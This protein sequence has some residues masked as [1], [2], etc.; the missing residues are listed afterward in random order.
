MKRSLLF[1]ALFLFGGSLFAQDFENLIDNPSFEEK[2]GDLRRSGQIRKAKGWV[3]G[4][5]E[6]ADLYTEEEEGSIG[7]PD[8]EKGRAL[9]H[10]G[11][12]YAGVRFFSFGDDEP[13][14]Y[15][16][17]KLSS[18]LKD[19]VTYCVKFYVSLSDRSIYGVNNI[20]AY[21]SKKDITTPEETSLIYEANVLDK[22][23][24]IFEDRQ[25]WEPVCAAYEAEGGEKYLTIGNFYSSSETETR[26]LEPMPDFSDKPPF[27]EAYY[28]IDDVSVRPVESYADCQCEEEEESKEPKVVYSKPEVDESDFSPEQKMN[29]RALYFGFF[30]A[31]LEDKA[32]EELGKVYTLLQENPDMEIEVIGHSDNKEQKK[33]EQ[34]THLKDKSGERAKA[35]VEYLVDKGISKD[36]LHLKAMQNSQPAS[37]GTDAFSRAKNRR[38]VFKVKE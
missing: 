17:S 24:K 29:N 15:I 16:S 34:Y 14:T 6:G 8:N 26:K 12:R 31:S 33:T 18:K 11:Q 36:R 19:G 32:K 38:V 3:S 1:F 30:S 4:S 9:P 21:L 23:N 28:Y 5:A 22:K 7:A 20:G 27:Y 13:R 2:N 25:L 37:S 35:A 10:T